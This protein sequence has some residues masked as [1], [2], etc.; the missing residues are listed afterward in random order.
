MMLGADLIAKAI[1]RQGVGTVFGLP[2]H[3]ESV[4]GALQREGIRL[5]HMR[6]ESPC[7]LAADAYAQMRRSLGVACVT[8]GPG[9]A[10]AVG[11]IASAFDNSAPVLIIAGRNPLRMLDARPMQELDH[12]RLVRSI[13]KWAQVVHD[14]SRLGEYVEM[15]ARIAMSGQPGPVLL[16]IPRDVANG[17]AD[18]AVAAASLGPVL[19][20]HPPAPA[21]EDIARAAALLGDAERPLIVAG[22]GAYWS[23]AGAELARLN[24]EFGI[25]VLLQGSSRGL[26]PEDMETVFPWPV[27]SVAAQQA[28]VVLFAGCR[29][30]GA[31]GFGTPPVFAADARFI[32]IDNDASEIG[33]GRPVEAPVAG[34]CRHALASMADALSARSP[35]RRDARWVKAAVAPRLERIESAGRSEEGQVH[36]LRMARELAARMPENSLFVGDG[37]NCNNWFK[38]VLRCT[39]S[40]GFIDHEPFGAMGV[41][42]PHAIGAVAALQEAGDERPVFLGTGDG[43][44]GQYL[45]EL[46]TASLHGLPIF[47]M[48]ANDGAWGSSRNI[49]LHLFNGTYGVDFAQS[50]YELVARGLE[51]HGEIA[52]TPA[53]VGPAFDRALEAVRAG[54]PAVVNVLVDPDSGLERRDPLLQM[55]TF[56]R[57]RFGGA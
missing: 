34:D 50:G 22:A 10:N 51:C 36:P 41:G 19:R 40:P 18:D 27:A 37:A 15:A 5:I 14:P 56:N 49:A 47:V 53:E 16:E 2:G 1:A 54:R 42:L 28:D 24:R 46:A 45:G 55:I 7:V 35:A 29:I 23:D 26:V 32:Q 33:R 57:V 8:S 13:V 30:A 43:A 9:L 11:G 21:S 44:F 38:A 6:H 52:T 4:F 17:E 12:A 3:L 31:I 39:H 20:A 48:V 25:P